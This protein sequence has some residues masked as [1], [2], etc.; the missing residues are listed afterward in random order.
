MPVL[1]SQTSLFRKLYQYTTIGMVSKA[2]TEWQEHDYVFCT[3]VG[4]HLH[5][6]RD[7][8]DQLKVL[9]VKAGLP[10]I[11]FHDLRHSSATMLLSMGVHPKIVQ[12]ILGHSQIS[13]TMD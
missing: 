13:M 5:P 11:R 7:V 10:D 9:L 6:T 4:T 12:E 8:L 3:S 2:G 1:F